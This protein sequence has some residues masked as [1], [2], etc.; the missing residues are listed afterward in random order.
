MMKVYSNLK[1]FAFPD[2]IQALSNRK[3]AAP[4]HVRIKPINRCN[5]DCWY[6]AYRVSNLQLGEDMNEKELIAEE[7]MHQIVDDLIDM[8]VRAV[9]FTGGGEPLIYKP[10][11]KIIKKLVKGGIKVGALS[12]GSNLKGEMADVFAEYATWIRVSLDA[13]DGESYAQARSVNKSAFNKLMKNLADFASRNSD[14]ELG[15]SFIIDEKNANHIF[16]TVQNLKD[17]GVKHVKLAGVV[18]SNDGVENNKYHKEIKSIVRDE[19]EKSLGISDSSF[20]VLDHYHDLDERFERDYN[21]CPTIQFTPVIG[22]DSYVY[23]CQDKAYTEGGKLGS[24]KDASFKDFWFSEENLQRAYAVNPSIHCK[25]N[26]A[27]HQKNQI[28]AD[29]IDTNSDHVLFT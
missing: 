28:I 1:A 23:T 9:T 11:A 8:K 26:C 18:V 4:V 15:T 13:W 7:K 16:E 5:H 22:G 29:F 17:C 14:C 12:N 21:M 20:K 24:I 2:R 25:H 19:I 6:C 3:L 10:L 27:N